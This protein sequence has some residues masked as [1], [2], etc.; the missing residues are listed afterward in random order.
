MQDWYW[1]NGNQLIITPVVP[2]GAYQG[3]FGPGYSTYLPG[4]TCLPGQPCSNYPGNCL[5]GQP[6]A[7]YPGQPYPGQYPN[8]Y[9]TATAPLQFQP[10]S[11]TVACYPTQNGGYTNSQCQT[12]YYGPN[13]ATTVSDYG[14]GNGGY[15]GYGGVGYCQTYYNNGIAT[16]SCS[17]QGISSYGYCNTFYNGGTATT[18]CSAGGFGYQPC[19]TYFNGG[20]STVTCTPTTTAS[21]YYTTSTQSFCNTFVNGGATTTSCTTNTYTSAT[22]T[23]YAIINGAPKETGMARGMLGQAVAGVIALGVAAL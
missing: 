8:G 10:T 16:Q 5:P 1:Q 20:Q 15:G 7:S 23:S 19:F 2:P 9:P 6:C 18:S 4:A 22:R 14:Y 12:I 17:A 11:Q 21:T 13:T 3:G